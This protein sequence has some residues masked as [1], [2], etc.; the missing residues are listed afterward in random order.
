MRNIISFKKNID[1]LESFITDKEWLTIFKIE[2]LNNQKIEKDIIKY[3][4]NIN[5]VRI[6]KIN[7]E[8]IFKD[9]RKKY[10]HYEKK[11]S[12]ETNI[13]NKWKTYR[14][15]YIY[16]GFIEVLT[17]G[18]IITEKILKHFKRKYKNS[19]LLELKKIDN[20]MPSILTNLKA[21]KLN[22][23]QKSDKYINIYQI[24]KKWQDDQHQFHDEVIEKKFIK[25][26]K[27][28]KEYVF[29]N[30][31]HL[32][33]YHD[34]DLLTLL[35]LDNKPIIDLEELEPYIYIGLKNSL[36]KVIGGKALG[37]ALLNHYKFKIPK[38]YII[39]VSS[40]KKMSYLN[41]VNNINFKSFSVR[42]SA[43]TED[44]KINSFAGI[45]QTKLNI[46]KKDLLHSIKEV[47][48]SQ[49]N[50]ESIL[51]S[52]HFK[53][54]KP[55]MS[56]IVQEYIEPDFAG[57]WIG[58]KIKSGILEYV[59]GC[60]ESLVSGKK[61]P[62]SEKWPNGSGLKLKNSFIGEIFTNA[63]KKY[64]MACD[65][66]WAVKNNTLYWLQYRPVTTNLNYIS[67]KSLSLLKAIPTSPGKAQGKPKYFAEPTN[68]HFEGILLADYTDPKWLSLM[69]DASGII[70]AEG[71]FLSHAAI[72]ARELGK[73]CIC[74]V[75]Y[76]VLDELRNVDF[77]E[78]NG[79]SG[80][81]KV[82]K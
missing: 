15:A 22:D 14:T 13:V 16:Y 49:N 80:E 29:N 27:E 5:G 62:T 3:I 58:K 61:T 19:Y 2:F 18:S 60:G 56:V 76:E 82:I 33:N 28:F 55:F 72:I 35:E 43:T 12:C 47:E 31:P 81:I 38:T 23:N 32:F 10:C 45:F 63:Q 41:F 34:N 30:Y 20:D 54:E 69:L 66:E 52:A 78:M 7:F 77:L 36:T 48:E 8:K 65:F 4:K 75:G 9:L 59:E 17:E 57:V 40:L 46:E 68:N 44:N 71:G 42:S 53:T 50:E 79:D 11:A 67:K 51:Y 21:I 73:P 6:D 37:L 70:T 26:Q 1:I 24:M 64:K 39:S 25:Y 74:G